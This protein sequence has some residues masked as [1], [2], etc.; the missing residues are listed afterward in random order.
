MRMF[1]SI[2]R[3]RTFLFVICALICSAFAGFGL[4]RSREVQDLDSH[5]R[6]PKARNM[7]ASDAS[8]KQSEARCPW[9][10]GRI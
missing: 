1:S 6:A 3:N 2:P 8:A 4:Q 9:L 7:V 5:A 10:A